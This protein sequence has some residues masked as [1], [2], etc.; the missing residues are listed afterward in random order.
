MKPEY[1]QP[2]FLSS[3]HFC[4]KQKTISNE[5]LSPIFCPEGAT[6]GIACEASVGF[7]GSRFSS[8][9]NRGKYFSVLGL[10]EKGEKAHSLEARP[11]GVLSDSYLK[12]KAKKPKGERLVPL[13]PFFTVDA[14]NDMHNPKFVSLCSCNDIFRCK[15]CEVKRM[16]ETQKDFRDF[17]ISANI[18]KPK[19]HAMKMLTI[20]YKRTSD[21]KTDRE[22]LLKSYTKLRH[23]S[24]WK[25]KVS[26]YKA[27]MEVVKNNIHLHIVITSAFWGQREISQAWFECTGTSFIVDIRKVNDVEKASL[28]LAKYVCKDTDE[29]LKAELA[30]FRDDNKGSRFVFTGRRPP[31]LDTI[32][33]TRHIEIPKCECCGENRSYHGQFGT[34]DEAEQWVKAQV[35]DPDGH[36]RRLSYPKK[37]QILLQ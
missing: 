31:S 14:C 1:S 2:T 18:D 11:K 17:M 23:R 12:S 34:T 25:N 7:S 9:W 28:E 35:R 30:L 26:F 33:T 22:G 13:K 4:Q 19:N 32:A 29:V 36:I 24:E 6:G 8:T 3:Q 5:Y 10:N 27:R 21:F 15:V 37:T 16:K 20:T